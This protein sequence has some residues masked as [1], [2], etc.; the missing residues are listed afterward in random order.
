[1]SGREHGLD[2]DAV[3]IGQSFLR[4]AIRK[5]ILMEE[6]GKVFGQ[7]GIWGGNSDFTLFASLFPLQVSGVPKSV[8][9]MICREQPASA[10]V[11]EAHVA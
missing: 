10:V 11:R 2:K 3:Q 6:E 8:Y 4:F 5:V 7:N 9:E 1:M